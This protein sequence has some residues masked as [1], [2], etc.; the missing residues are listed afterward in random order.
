MMRDT[1]RVIALR[2]DV[3]F[4]GSQQVTDLSRTRGDGLIEDK[5]LKAFK[6]HAVIGVTCA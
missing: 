1:F 2:L 6:Q 5:G 4:V 3:P